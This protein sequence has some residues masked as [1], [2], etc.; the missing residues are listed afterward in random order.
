MTSFGIARGAFFGAAVVVAATM[1][2]CSIDTIVEP[3]DP[4]PAPSGSSTTEPVPSTTPTTPPTT[5]ADASTP[6]TSPPKDAGNGKDVI[7]SPECKAWCDT[8]VAAG[9]RACD[10]L[11]CAIARGSCDAAERA[12]LDCQAKTGR[13]TCTSGGM[14]IVHNCRRDTTLCN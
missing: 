1:A 6:D 5:L 7:G 4:S 8:K 12:Y 14:S 3:L 2:A 13:F 10:S 9:C 11:D